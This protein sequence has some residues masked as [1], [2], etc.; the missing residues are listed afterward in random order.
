MV[1]SGGVMAG[2]SGVVARTEAPGGGGGRPAVR[3]LQTAERDG[4]P[5]RTRPRGR[6]AETTTDRVRRAA[7]GAGERTADIRFAYHDQGSWMGIMRSMTN[8]ALNKLTKVCY[9]EW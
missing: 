9:D 8:N 7:S 6:A 2:A 1:E 5:R 4:R 3:D